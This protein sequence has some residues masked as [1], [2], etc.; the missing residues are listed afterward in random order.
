MGELYDSPGGGKTGSL[1]KWIVFARADM[2]KGHS[3]VRSHPRAA[4]G[5]AV[6]LLRMEI[7]A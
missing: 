1:E 3:L 7:L 2:Q 6:V 5:V 4:W